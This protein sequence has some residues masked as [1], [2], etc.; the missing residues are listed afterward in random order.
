[1]LFLLIH[2]L[3]LFFS[4]GF[5]YHIGLKTYEVRFIYRKKLEKSA[6]I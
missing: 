1:M 4:N 5:F 2:K 3:S 6:L